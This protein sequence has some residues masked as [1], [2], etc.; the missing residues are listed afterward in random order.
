MNLEE[1]EQASIQ[2]TTELNSDLTLK[3]VEVAIDKTRSN[4]AFMEI[5]NEAMKNKNAQALLHKFFSICF[6]SGICPTEWY[7]SNIKPI[8]KKDKDP[9]DPLNNRCI[10]IMC[11]VAKVYSSILNKRIQ[12]YLEENNLLVDEQNGFRATRS[13]IDHIFSLCSILRNR[14][15]QG[16]DTFISF[17]DFKKAFDSVDRTILLYKIQQLGITGNMYHAISYI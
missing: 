8:P 12:N 7:K 9:R 3:E 2:D 15:L 14:K 5:P 6:K 10:T 1:Q 17:V 4:K 16:Y 13:C 11:C